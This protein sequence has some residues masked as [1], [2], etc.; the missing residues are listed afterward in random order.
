[1]PNVIK[2]RQNKKKESIELV[3][4]FFSGLFSLNSVDINLKVCGFLFLMNKKPIVYRCR[5]GGNIYEQFKTFTQSAKQ[6]NIYGFKFAIFI[7]VSSRS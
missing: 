3:P 4:S 7:C 1:M 5:T 6:R 2:L